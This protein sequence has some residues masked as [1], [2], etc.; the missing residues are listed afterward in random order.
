MSR[1]IAL[2]LAVA[3]CGNQRA[4]PDAAS[5][6]SG[7]PAPAPNTAALE[8]RLGKLEH[9]VDK[10]V[11]A[12]DKSL[13][14]VEPDPATVYSVPLDARD[15]VEGPTDAAATLV[16]GFELM[17]AY[18]ATVAPVVAQVLAKHPADVRVVWKYLPIHGAPAIGAGLIACGA[19]KQNKW[20]AVRAALIARLFTGTPPVPHP[21]LASYEQLRP[22]AIQAG[23][24]GARLD[25]D[26]TTCEP[27]FAATKAIFE[28]IG[29][30]TTP[31]LFLNGRH[32]GGARDLQSLDGLVSTAI[33]TAKGQAA[34]FYQREV[35]DAGV[36]RVVGRF[37]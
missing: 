4:A 16:V 18:S 5:V 19:A 24:D 22:I 6:A 21:E 31:A 23:L 33:A 32:V 17:D 1:L 28:P 25:A 13:G 27:W 26:R 35:V 34:G 14:P 3:A 12:I 10:L 36:K 37:E 2:A 9:T 7:A 8:A 30:H 11:A 15:P 20:P 29:I